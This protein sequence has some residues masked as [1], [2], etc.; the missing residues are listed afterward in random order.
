MSAAPLVG[1][2]AAVIVAA[3]GDDNGTNNVLNLP[4][5]ARVKWEVGLEK[6]V[7]KT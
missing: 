2:S 3:C 6:M 5:F 4:S 7:D 1:R